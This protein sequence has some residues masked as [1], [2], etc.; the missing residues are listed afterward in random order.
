MYLI[1]LSS[2]D[3]SIQMEI[4]TSEVTDK[5]RNMEK[6]WSYGKTEAKKLDN[7]IIILK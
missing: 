2:L 1:H 5:A 4:T 7:G 6:E 3:A